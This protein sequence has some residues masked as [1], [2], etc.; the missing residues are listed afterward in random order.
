[1]NENWYLILELEFD[2]P[3]EDQAVIDQRIEDKRKFWASKFNDFKRGAEYKGYHDRINE[4]K[5]IMGDPVAR[6][7]QAEAARKDV[8]DQ[9]DIYLTIL[10]KRGGGEIFEDV[11]KKVANKYEVS[12]NVINK[13]VAYLGI[14][15]GKRKVDF[16]AL[17]LS[18]YKN[19]PN[20]ADKYV[21]MKTYLQPLNKANL[22]DFLNPGTIKNY[23]SLPCNTLKSRAQEMK[24]NDFYKHDTASSAGKKICELCEDTFEDENSKTIYDEYLAWGKRRSILDEAKD[25]AKIEDGD[26]PNGQDAYIGQLTELLKDGTLAK[27]VFIAFCKA[28]KIAYNHNT[29][30]ENN[31]NIKVCRCGHF[32]DV[33]KQKNCS[34]CHLELVIKCPNCGTE[35]DA[36]IPGCKCGFKFENIDRALALCELA[37]QYIKSMDFE[38][39]NAHLTDAERYWPGSSE[40]KAKREELE[41]FKQRIGDAA[42]NMRTAVLEKRYYEAKKQYA[43]IKKRFSEF[44][45]ADLEAEITTAIETAKS[46]F[47]K[48]KAQSQSS[49]KEIIENCT[50]AHDSCCD[51]PGVRELISKYPPQTPANLRISTDGNTKTNILSWNESTSEG[52]VYYSIVRKRDSIPIN[53]TDGDLVARVN[54]SSFNDSKI[55]PGI[56]YYYAIFAERAGVY[57]K[58]LSPRT[59]AMNL[60]EI[61][62][63]TITPGDAMLELEWD[64]IPSGSTV[65]LFRTT[66][67]GKEKR[68][69]SNNSAGYLDS[70]L[71]NDKVYNYRLHLV[72]NINGQKQMTTGVT[73]SGIPTKPPKAIE[74]L[75]VKPVQDNTFQATWENPDNSEVRLYCSTDR[76][77]YKC[78]EIVSQATLESKMRRLA[79]TKLK[80]NSGTFQFKDE[81]RLYITAV[82]VKSNSAV[83]GAIDRASKGESV[84]I[85]NIVA[86][87]NKI[88][89]F[90][91]LPKEATGFVVLYRFDKYPV[92]ISDVQSIRE[93]INIKQYQADSVLVIKDLKQQNYYFTVFAEFER[94][95]EKDYS[96]GM[97]YLFVNASKKV[98]TYSISVTKKKFGFGE[99]NVII[100]FEAGEESFNLP[101]IDIYSAIGNVPMFKPS[102]KL[103]H[104]IP[105]Q[106]FTGSLKVTIPLPG[107]IESETFIK[108][109]LKD[110][111]LHSSYK[112]QLKVN[113]NSKIR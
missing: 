48:A 95:G 26:L 91:D 84:Q 70:G 44:N 78:G 49:E 104:S 38:V 80:S 19:K 83:I 69:N 68:I 102:A 14:K 31:K 113:S 39:A 96:T 23:N 103:F 13:R 106:P 47:D 21:S 76:P 58:P 12:D 30:N 18:Y 32:N 40:V 74:I 87:N 5:K 99:N 22:Y 24:K 59:P 66:D 37:Q 46:Y 2:P 98:I 71:R 51:Y 112:L 72:Y 90:I 34:N 100:S 86:V 10:G 53:N 65:E 50:K 73:I 56:G 36:N 4:I 82:V 94:D 81:G 9:L 105:A 11:V 55:L 75:S 25:I 15:I 41:E 29:E 52:T 110:D 27:N 101:D 60:F 42:V 62:N 92:D 97:N 8:Y 89:I 77:E 20:G 64:P 28:E 35:N 63:V 109:F 43:A 88:N 3:V 45:E 111:K 61:A 93:D 85:K 6:K 17:Y 57:S 33:S 79:V 54:V 7:E 67:G 108:A 1:M 107:E 16:H